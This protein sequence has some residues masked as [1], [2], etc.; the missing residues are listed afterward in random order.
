MANATPSAETPLH[1]LGSRGWARSFVR[2]SQRK[3]LFLVAVVLFVGFVATAAL[4]EVLAPYAFD[5]LDLLQRARPPSWGSA[6]P[7]GTDPLGRDV[8]SQIIYGIRTSLALAGT[9]T[10]IAAVVGSTLGTLAG[11]FGGWFDVL[12]MRL[13]DMQL[14]IPAFFLALAGSVVIGRGIVSLTIVLAL[15]SWAQFARTARASALTVREESFVEAAR[16]LGA[17]DARINFAHILPNIVAPLLIVFSINL[18]HAI[19]VEASLSFVGMGL[20]AGVPSLGSIINN[21]Y[22]HLLA[23][24]W[25]ISI[26]PGVALMLI[27]LS[28]NTITDSLRDMLDTRL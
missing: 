21:G 2:E 5:D 27:V 20:P 17:D 25:W 23:G 4:A 11:Y 19:M 13:V 28:I 7:L 10:I 24:A 1:R 9:A 26:L 6:H 3:P 22:A 8:L 12:L 14:A 16:G 15:V 18:P